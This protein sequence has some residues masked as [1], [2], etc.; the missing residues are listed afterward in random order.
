MPFEFLVTV[1]AIFSAAIA[2]IAGFGIGSL[3]TPVLNIQVELKLAVAIVSI[4]HFVATVERF[5][6]LR[7]N[8]DRNV[9]LRFGL[10]SAAGGL[11][12]AYLNTRF[13]SPLLAIVFGILLLF[14]GGMGL[15]GLSQ[16]MRFGRKSSWI[17][18]F[19]SGMFGGLVGNQGGI[20]AAAMLSFNLSPTAFV[21]TSTAIGVIVD[22]AR[23]PVYF[24]SDWSAIVAEWKII[25]LSIF[26]VTAGTFLGVKIL[27][28]IPRAI[29][30]KLVS[31]LIC[32]LGV[33][34]LYKGLAV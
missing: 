29:F 24:A 9:I 18:G 1:T 17:A 28:A 25:V 31:A 16:R 4:P 5:W 13:A 21:A 12:G 30:Q 10:T 19:L 32:L 20:R 14:A 33:A 6:R 8:V 2:A 27:A 34:M 7:K 11:L 26:G 15:L 22:L 23:M 3:M